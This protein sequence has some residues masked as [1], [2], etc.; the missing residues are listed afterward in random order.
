M[1]AY[2]ML[3]YSSDGPPPSQIDRAVQGLGLRRHG[4][5]Y[6][7]EA[8]SEADLH[9]VLDEL[10]GVLKGTG[11]RYRAS[12]ERPERSRREGEAREEV[13]RWADAGLGG[14][15][16]L[17]ALDR[18]IYEFKQEALR[19]M[20]AAVD[21]VVGLRRMEMQEAKDRQHREAVKEEIGI[22]LRSAGGR[23]FQEVLEAFD[24][25]EATLEGVMQE[26]I[27][28]GT[29]VAHQQGHTVIYLLAGPMLRSLSR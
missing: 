10:H 2:I 21:H 16:L 28:E 6:L 3:E 20:Q 27:D 13:L 19:A 11:T 29:I 18:D 24:M 22:L 14:Q 5:H 17:E 26:M 1:M 4:A 8:S 9:R 15:D 23:S 7:V 12:L 25:D